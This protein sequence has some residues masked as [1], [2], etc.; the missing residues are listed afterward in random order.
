MSVKRF[1]SH[2]DTVAMGF[3]K[4]LCR[5]MQLLQRSNGGWVGEQTEVDS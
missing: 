3:T 5:E 2:P 1:K 4:R